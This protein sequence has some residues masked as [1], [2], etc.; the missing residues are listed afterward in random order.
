MIQQYHSEVI[1]SNEN[2]C[3]YIDLHLNVPRWLYLKARNKSS[4]HQMMNR[5]IV[6]FPHNGILPGNKKEQI[7]DT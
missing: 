1:K 6:A 2:K 3:P 7:A 5:Y 4:I